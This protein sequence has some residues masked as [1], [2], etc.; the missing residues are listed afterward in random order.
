MRIVSEILFFLEMILLKRRGLFDTMKKK[1]LFLIHRY[2]KKVKRSGRFFKSRLNP[3]LTFLTR[4][5]L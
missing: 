2:E 1:I 5:G 4:L 3:E